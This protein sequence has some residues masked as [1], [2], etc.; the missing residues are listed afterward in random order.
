MRRESEMKIRTDFVTNS[1]SSSFVIA[2]KSLPAIDDE[3]LQ[4]YPFLNSYSEM[5]EKILFTSGDN[6][7]SEGEV[8]ETIEDYERSIIDDYYWTGLKTIEAVLA[9]EGDYLTAQYEKCKDYLEKRYKIL[10]K[11]VGY[12][13]EYCSNLL[14]DLARGNENFVIIEDGDS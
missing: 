1:S 8:I 5:I 7:T 3:T 6:E 14:H 4:K 12:R 10:N 2:Y 9:E 13:D 11:S